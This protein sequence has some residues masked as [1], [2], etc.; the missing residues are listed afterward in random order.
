MIGRAIWSAAHASARRRASVAENPGPPPPA[1]PPPDPVLP[2]EPWWAVSSWEPNL[3]PVLTDLVEPGGVVFDVGANAGGLSV[4]MSRLVGPRGVVCA[5]EASPRIVPVLHA[6][7][8]AAGCANVQVYDRAIFSRSGERLKLYA[9]EHLNDSLY[10]DPG[11]SAC[12]VATVALDDF[13]AHTGLRPHL[14]KADIEGAEYDM[15]LGM[16]R[17]LREVRPSIILEQTPEDE[18]ARRLLAG[19]DYVA[20]DTGSYRRIERRKDFAPGVQIANVLLMPRERAEHDRYFRDREPVYHARIDRAVFEEAADG[21]ATM[22]RDLALPA[23]RFVLSADFDA[24]GTD[25]EVY[26]LAEVNGAL[27]SRFHAHTRMIATSYRDMVLALDRPGR[28]RMHLRL[29]QGRDPTV[30]WRGVDVWRV[31]A[32][33]GWRRPPGL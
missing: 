25:N 12:E 20:M 27:A 22:T 1:A 5:F 33:D 23:G 30:D 11:S 9:G 15:L 28:V 21:S 2:L 4:L 31:P 10:G 6:N 26:M 7:L 13:I 24:A 16:E 32:F 17:T 18:R 29:V 14:V 3:Q 19:H 8:L